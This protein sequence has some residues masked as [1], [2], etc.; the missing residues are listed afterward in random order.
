MKAWKQ[1][2]RKTAFLQNFHTCLSAV[3]QQAG[4]DN[5]TATYRTPSLA[6]K[7]GRAL[8]KTTKLLKRQLIQERSYYSIPDVDDFHDLCESEWG[9]EISRHGL[10]T[11]RQQKRNKVN[12]L[13]VESDMK[14][15][16]SYIREN[17][18]NVAN[19]SAVQLQENVQMMCRSCTENWL[20]SHWQ[21]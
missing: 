6:L 10:D 1:H 21:I 20:M 3:K 14:K 19:S 13:P 5:Q 18:T 4:F 2:R 8:K 12:L 17:S 11:L 9:D 7:V 16:V 15:L